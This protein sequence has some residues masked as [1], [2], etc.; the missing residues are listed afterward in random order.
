[1]ITSIFSYLIFPRK[2]KALT[3]KVTGVT[4]ELV[5][6]L[7][8]KLKKIYD[9]SEFDC[10]LDIVFRAGSDGSQNNETREL[11]VRFYNAPT[12]ENGKHIA[13]QLA[14]ATNS[15]SGVGLLFVI[16]GAI[17]GK[18]KILL[19]RF[20]AE[21]GVLVEENKDSLKV[22]FVEKVFMKDIRYYKSAL[23]QHGTFGADFWEG[24]AIDKQS[25][26]DREISNYWISDFLISDFA[27]TS[28]R[29]SKKLAECMRTVLQKS[30]DQLAKS[31]ISALITLSKNRDAEQGSMEDFL[32]NGTCSE[33]TIKEIKKQVSNVLFKHAFKF[34]HNEF[35]KHL[36]IRVIELDNG[37]RISAP[38]DIF[39]EIV[40]KEYLDGNNTLYK[41]RGNEVTAYF[42]KSNK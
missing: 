5:G 25:G 30:S 6:K 11:I 1:M 2:G 14:K 7:F 35:S 23:F 22:D 15:S 26:D 24:K 13:E 36:S 21:E 42:E 33:S 38:A 9:K 28:E 17:N 18:T 19:S 39:D 40:E 27:L 16:L 31:E 37:A 10:D 3:K 20:K 29:G 34:S 8:D 32:K 41:I 4:V 12:L